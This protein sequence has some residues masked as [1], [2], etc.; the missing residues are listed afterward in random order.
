MSNDSSVVL[1]VDDERYLAEFYTKVLGEQHEVRTAYRGKEA[2]E[3]YG[4]DVD[5][6]LLDRRMPDL[7]GKEVLDRLA[8]Q[9]GDCRVAMVTA[10][11]PEPEVVNMEFDDYLL[12]PVREQQLHETVEQLLALT[13]YDE[14]LQEYHALTAKRAVLTIAKSEKSLAKNEEYKSL[15][16]RIEEIETEFEQLRGELGYRQLQ[17]A[18]DI[19]DFEAPTV[20]Q[21]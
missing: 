13:T 11:E 5:V 9:P 2:L 7:P 21:G 16:A 6:V 3:K 14:R 18:F 15:E 10:V 1:V 4:P 19:I 17:N 12:K 20:E 8:E